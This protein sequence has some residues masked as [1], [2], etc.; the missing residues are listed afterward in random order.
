M[1]DK[2]EP[3]NAKTLKQ[4]IYNLTNDD[5]YIIVLSKL[6]GDAID[7]W[8]AANSFRLNDY[9][10]VRNT[11]SQMIYEMHEE[12]VKKATSTTQ[13]LQVRSQEKEIKNLLDMQ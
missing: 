11:L 8:V 12:E 7:T 1:D 2:P 3:K 5:K 6:N 9:P 4:D 13:E 10:I